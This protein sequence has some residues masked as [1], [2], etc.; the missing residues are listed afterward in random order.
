VRATASQLTNILSY[1]PNFE[2]KQQQSR[3]ARGLGLVNGF[4]ISEEDIKP[5]K[6]W[7]K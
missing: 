6:Y 1:L 3:F 4:L 7:S 2:L 5:G